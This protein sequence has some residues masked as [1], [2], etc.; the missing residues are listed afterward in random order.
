LICGLLILLGAIIFTIISLY[1]LIIDEKWLSNNTLLFIFG[2]SLFIF[3]IA[4]LFIASRFVEKTNKEVKKSE[5]GN[6]Q[7]ENGGAPPIEGNPL[8]ALLGGR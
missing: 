2:I 7:P 5:P 1:K 8:A 3:S 4:I 6:Q